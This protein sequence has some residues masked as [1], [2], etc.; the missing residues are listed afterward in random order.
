MASY[1]DQENQLPARRQ[2]LG[3][4]KDNGQ[5]KGGLAVSNAANTHKLPQQKQALKVWLQLF[6]LVFPI[7]FM[8]FTLKV[9]YVS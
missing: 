2:V 4:S 8:Q 1:F 6:F 5:L 7:L 3:Q 9:V